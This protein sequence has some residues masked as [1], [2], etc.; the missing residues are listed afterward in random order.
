MAGCGSVCIIFLL[1]GYGELRNSGQAA[2]SLE[3]T[4]MSQSSD[5][6]G[7]F[8]IKSLNSFF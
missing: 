7:L 5:E 1:F 6:D 4:D 2:I 8:T 3:L